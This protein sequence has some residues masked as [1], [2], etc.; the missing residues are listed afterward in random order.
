MKLWLGCFALIMAHVGC[1][2]D[3][4]SVR[5]NFRVLPLK[6]EVPPPVG[7]TGATPQIIFDDGALNPE[8]HKQLIEHLKHKQEQQFRA[9][10]EGLQVQINSCR[11]LI[12]VGKVQ[13][14]YQALCNASVIYDQQMLV[15]ATA[16]AERETRTRGLPQ[17]A[18]DS[19]PGRNP[20]MDLE[21]VHHVVYESSQ[22]VLASLLHPKT[23]AKQHFR[24][25][26]KNIDQALTSDDQSLLRAIV[27]S[28]SQRDN[29]EDDPLLEQLLQHPNNILGE[30]AT[31]SLALRCHPRSK[32]VLYDVKEK[33]PVFK[34][35]ALRGLA[36]VK[37]TEENLMPRR[38]KVQAPGPD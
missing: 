34:T 5:D 9:A 18:I 25:S 17:S 19:Q 27:S 20:W 15:L 36:C 29:P 30:E 10:P 35:W 37:A 12:A 32:S 14:Q 1:V 7:Y 8:E 24:F 11:I 26:P 6:T 13:T 4:L 28:Q 22:K 21:H 16:R 3:K 38:E 2:T 33:G 23:E 31:R